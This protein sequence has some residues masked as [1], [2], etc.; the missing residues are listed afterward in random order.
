MY[1]NLYWEPLSYFHD[2]F[3]SNIMLCHFLFK[4]LQGL[5]QL[6][7][8]V[9]SVLSNTL[10]NLV[11]ITSLTSFLVA[12]LCSATWASFLFIS[13]AKLLPTWAFCLDHLSLRSPCA[14][15]AHS[16]GQA[17]IL[18]RK[19]MLLSLKKKK[20]N[21]GAVDLQCCISFWCMAKQFLFSQILFHY[22]LLQGTNIV[23]CAI[24]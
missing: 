13:S 14:F 18:S 23:P 3:K 16:Q 22:R 21:W 6:I 24:H 19:N 11:P 17:F 7:A 8:E 10:Q 12:W 1:V 9:H 15:L 4:T 2:H 20:K 5:F